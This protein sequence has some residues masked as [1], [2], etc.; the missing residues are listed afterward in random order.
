MRV[1]AVLRIVRRKLIV[2]IRIILRRDILV[3]LFHVSGVIDAVI[4][5]LLVRIRGKRWYI[6]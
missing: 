4:L 1:H 5:L 3:I 2:A 6:T